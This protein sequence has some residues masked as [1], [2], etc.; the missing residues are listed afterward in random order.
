MNVLVTGATGFVGTSVINTLAGNS[1]YSPIAVI[2]NTENTIPSSIETILIED[3]RE[4]NLFDKCLKKIDV[5]IHTAARVHVMND[6]ADNPLAEF[7]KINVDSTLNFARQSA[8]AGV[9]RFIFIS[10]IKVNGE[11]TCKNKPFTEL[12]TPL[13]IDP[14]GISKYETE[15]A[16]FLLAKDVE[17]EI[18]CIRPPLVYGE[19]VKANFL[20]LMTWLNKNFPLPFGAINNKRSLIGLDNLVDLIVICIEHPAASNQVFLASD[21]NDL[22]TTEL[23]RHVSKSMEINPLLLPVPQ[24]LLVGIL[25]VLGKKKL[26]QRLCGSLQIDISKAKTLLGWTPPISVDDGLMKTTSSFL[27]R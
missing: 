11:S 23:L 24:W 18:V 7:R 19:G 26:A 25:I 27:R 12:D 10:S 1:K 16:L 4:D 15:K 21:D 22:S 8:E 2:R 3:F 13:P 17:M 14:Y 6:K 5:V 9:K 20:S